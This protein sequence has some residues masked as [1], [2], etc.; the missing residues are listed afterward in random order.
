M[1]RVFGVSGRSGLDQLRHYV[2]IEATNIKMTGHQTTKFAVLVDLLAA[3]SMSPATGKAGAIVMAKTLRSVEEVKASIFPNTFR[4][5]LANLKASS[6]A[7]V[8]ASAMK[9]IPLAG[10]VLSGAFHIFAILHAGLPKEFNVEATSRFSANIIMAVGS[11]ADSV[12]RVLTNFRSVRWNAQIR[13]AMGSDFQRLMI[14]SLRF[15]KWFGGAAGV[16]GFVF[17]AVSSFKEF[18]RIA[19]ACSAIGGGVLTYGALFSI[20]LAPGWIV[21]AVVLMLGAAIYLALNIKNEIQ[22]WLMSCL[23]R[24]IPQ[25]EKNVPEILPEKL[26]IKALE[27]ALQSGVS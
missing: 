8:S 18:S 13:M 22:I 15:V 14:R 3:E 17:D 24:S 16:V 27:K 9:I 2:D 7:M 6:P 5:K 12:E 10:S 20:V 4:S 26:E 11:V 25:G 23:W 1:A 19:Y 21:L